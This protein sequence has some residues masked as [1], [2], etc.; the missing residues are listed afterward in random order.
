MIHHSPYSEI[1]PDLN[2]PY[3]TVYLIRHANP[4]YKLQKKLGDRNMP[5][6]AEGKRQ[7]KLLAKN[8]AKREIEVIYSSEF[9]RAKETADYFSKEIRKKIIINKKLNEIDWKNWHRIKYFNT[10]ETK[11]SKDLKN[12]KELD[13]RLDKMQVKGRRLLWDIYK[14]NKAKR[15]AV[16]CHGNIIKSILTSILNADVI[17]FLSLEIFQSSISKLIIDSQGYVKIN[18]INEVSHLPKPPNEDL[19]VTLLYE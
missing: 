19:F 14:K 15:V 5:L 7:A 12:Y 10:C 17:G 4:E 9:K 18:H 2:K 16:F 13:A 1:K 3:T 6:S 11:R 8:L